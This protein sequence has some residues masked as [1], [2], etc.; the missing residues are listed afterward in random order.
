VGTAAIDGLATEAM[1]ATDATWMEMA[2]LTQS[3]YLFDTADSIVAEECDD[4]AGNRKA[5]TVC[6][7]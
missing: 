5:E 3:S 4:T 7:E 2:L 1:K 6:R